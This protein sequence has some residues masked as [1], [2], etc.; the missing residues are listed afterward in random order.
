MSD[1][2][3]HAGTFEHSAIRPGFPP[4]DDRVIAKGFRHCRQTIRRDFTSMAWAISNLPAAEHGA[5][6]SLLV[7]LQRG[8]E[9][10]GQ[11]ATEQVNQDRIANWRLD[12][13]DTFSG[14]AVSP[15]LCAL[16]V[17]QDL[18]RIPR[19]FLYDFIEGIDWLMRFP[20]PEDWDALLPVATRTG[21]TIMA[22]CAP[23]LGSE[24][25]AATLPAM[26]LGQAITV[27]WWLQNLVTDLRRGIQRLAT[28]DFT[29]CEL[30]PSALLSRPAEKPLAWFARL[31][32]HRIE[33]LL[34]E[35]EPLLEQLGY[36]GVRVVKSL[37]AVCFRASNNLRRRPECLVDDSG[38]LPETDWK[39]LRT[40]HFLGLEP[41][42][43]FEVRPKHH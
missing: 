11:R 12:L 20:P 7:Y 3:I 4:I 26:K 41:E 16:V 43:P 15:E 6:C 33:N 36:D 34:R 30:S 23:I 28:A 2:E 19:E 18:Y 39:K 25:S 8:M 32:A 31:H 21:G 9:L 37:I 42:L 14:Q 29:E 22:A 40:R 38:I 24:S 17:T 5:V 13:T 10:A 1:P 27:C 35:S